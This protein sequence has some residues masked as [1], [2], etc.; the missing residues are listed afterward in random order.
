M[1][2]DSELTLALLLLCGTG[3]RDMKLH[4]STDRKAYSGLQA[5]SGSSSSSAVRTTV[6]ES[7]F[8]DMLDV[9]GRPGERPGERGGMNIVP[10]L[11]AWVAVRA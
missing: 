5:S 4:G 1:H 7:C 2:D 11:A 10:V 6:N 3:G 8:E 9:L